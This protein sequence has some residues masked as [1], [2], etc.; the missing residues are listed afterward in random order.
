M[1]VYILGICLPGVCFV[2]GEKNYFLPKH[3]GIK[4]NGR[5]MRKQYNEWSVKDKECPPEVKCMHVQKAEEKCNLK[6]DPPEMKCT[7]V[8]K[9][10]EKCNLKGDP[11]EMKCTHVQKAEEKCNLKGKIKVEDHF[12]ITD[13]T[14]SIDELENKTCC[15]A[16]WSWI[17]WEHDRLTDTDPHAEK[18]WTVEATVRRGRTGEMKVGNNTPANGTSDPPSN[19][20]VA[21]GDSDPPSN[22]V[23]AGGASDTPSNGECKGRENSTVDKNGSN[24]Q[25]CSM[26]SSIRDTSGEE[27]NGGRSGSVDKSGFEMQPQV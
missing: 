18:E 3:D 25:P 26:E 19:Q 24:M 4:V 5:M 8:Q 10:E 11:P 7:H 6:G 16:L 15:D 21:G 13:I 1:L 17:D 9:T 23:V 2:W 12:G 20:V 14:L 22:Q 27:G